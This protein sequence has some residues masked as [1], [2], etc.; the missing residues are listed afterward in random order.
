MSNKVY[1][2]GTGLRRFGRFPNLSHKEFAWPVVR[3]A[4]LESGLP[5][6]A[7]DIA[8]AS[9]VFGGSLI[10]QQILGQVGLTGIPVINVENA[11][12]SS[13]TAVHEAAARI[14]AGQSE[15]AIV[16]GVD[17]LSKLGGGA[18][19]LNDEDWEATQGMN[20]PTLYAMRAQRYMHEH[21][22][23]AR[24]LS[25]VSV[26]ARKH[27]ALNPLAQ[28][29][30]PLTLEE[31]EASREISHPLRLLHCCPTG[32]GAAAVVLGSQRF[33]HRS[34][35]KTAVEIKATALHS[36]RFNLGPLPMTRS[37]V[38]S[39]SAKEVYEAASIGPQ[40][41]DVAELH[42]S[43]AIAELMYYEA[44]QFCEP[45]GA[46]ELLRSGVTS[47]GGKQ[48][49]NP[50]GGL[51]SRGHPVAASG[52]AQIVEITRQLQG[53]AGP[54]QVQGARTGLAH[55]TGG[56]ISGFEHGACAVTV[57]QR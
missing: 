42:D 47:L 12:S 28:F 29:Q 6:D 16:V 51:L 22:I 10:G 9:S 43:F 11:C 5:R 32:D 17:M 54:H 57:L 41:I 56:G 45:G 23:A 40:D 36:G 33:L 15:A 3:E 21:G 2:L 49:V 44:F 37:H 25:E 55:V 52:A 26:K 31:V 20:M 35:Y 46:L 13:A 24:D 27:G 1:V 34:A 4:L 38:S 39:L 50:S 14:R 19:P 18:L 7:I 48:V 30:T 53:R 8:Y